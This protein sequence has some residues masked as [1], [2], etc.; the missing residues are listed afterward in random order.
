[1]SRLQILAAVMFLTACVNGKPYE[2][3][4]PADITRPPAEATRP[5]ALPARPD[6][7]EIVF[8]GQ[9]GGFLTGEGLRALTA[10]REATEANRDI[11]TL[12]A[13]QAEQIAAAFDKLAAAYQ[14]QRE[15]SAIREDLL[16]QARRDRFIDGL[17]YKALIG[18]GLVAAIAGQ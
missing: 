8:Q 18:L 1:M 5:I 17:I 3:P 16:I 9:A 7:R 11:A 14:R 10:Y 4:P 6:L 13:I 2:L 12:N 15:I